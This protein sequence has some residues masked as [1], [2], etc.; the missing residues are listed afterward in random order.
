MADN[1]TDN[2]SKPNLDTETSIE[3]DVEVEAGVNESQTENA[4]NL[5][6]SDS[7]PTNNQN[8][9]PDIEDSDF[10]DTGE[11]SD[12]EA[13][14]SSFESQNKTS[15]KKPI[16]IIS[17]AFAATLIIAAILF[18]LLAPDSKETKAELTPGYVTSIKIP[19]KSR[20]RMKTGLELSRENQATKTNPFSKVDEKPTNTSIAASSGSE[21]FLRFFSRSTLA[22]DIILKLIPI[23]LNL[24]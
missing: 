13:D 12:S 16:I 2:N 6:K 15:R 20:K 8:E 7:N 4:A 21:K 11:L 3:E 9:Q 18:F 17:S 10:S 1:L 14:D 24:Y 5:D 19:P 23:T 22:P